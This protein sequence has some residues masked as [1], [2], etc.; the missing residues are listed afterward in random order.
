MEV[1][2]G[3]LRLMDL[4]PGMDGVTLTLT[5]TLTLMDLSP[6]MDGVRCSSTP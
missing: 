2:G 4:S 5:L 3:E 6:G 1:I